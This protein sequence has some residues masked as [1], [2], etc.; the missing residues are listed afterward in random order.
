MYSIY[1]EGYIESSEFIKN[2]DFIY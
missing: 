2:G 1:C